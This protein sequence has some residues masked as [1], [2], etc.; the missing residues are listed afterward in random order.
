MLKLLARTSFT[1]VALLLLLATP[2]AFGAH[3][4][5]PATTRAAHHASHKPRAPRRARRKSRAVV[6]RAKSHRTDLASVT[7][8]LLGESS[9]ESQYDSLIAGQAEAFRLRAGASGFAHVAHVYIPLPN[10]ARTVIVGLYTNANNHPGSLLR[11]GS[12]SISRAGSWTA[13]S[14][15]QLELVAGKSYWL[16]ILG[17]GGILR[18]RDRAHG[19]CPSETSAR[20]TLGVLPT[21]WKTGTIYSDCPVS[22]YVTA[23]RPMPPSERTAPVEP[24]SPLEPTLPVEPIPPV[25]PPPPPTSPVNAMLPMI[26]GSTVEGQV[27]SASSGTWSGSPTSYVYQ[28]Q[29]CGSSGSGCVNVG[30]ATATSYTLA[31]S[32]VGHTMRVVV[33]AS[34]A[35]GSSSATAAATATVASDTPPPPV[36][37]TNTVLPSVSGSAVEG[38][39]LSASDGTWTGNPMSYA[40]QWEDC[41]T[42][43]ESCSN[44]SGATASSY[45]LAA[46]DVGG[47]MRVA[48]SASNAGGSASATSAPTAAVTVAPGEQTTWTAVGTPPR[49]DAQAAAL[50][51]NKAEQRPGNIAANDY[52][53][54]SA[55]L[56]SFHSAVNPY[57]QT[58]VQENPLNSYVDGLDGMTS[59]STDDLI[60]WGA[61]KWGIPADWLR[62]E[63][64]RESDWDQSNLGD[65]ASVSSSWYVLYPPLAEIAG[66]SEVFETMGIAGVKWR[67]DNSVGGGT[68]PLRWK[69]TAFNIDYQAAEVRYFYDGYCNRCTSGYGSGQQWNSIGAW[70]EPSP[71]ANAGARWYI[72][73]VQRILSEKPWLSPSF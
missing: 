9:V 41:N 64:V 26:A 28:W 32:D 35:G 16:A 63:Y 55:Q 57:G 14:I 8:V 33:I 18:Y 10:T 59:P 15:A 48:V 61:R 49:S 68:E 69:S 45:T 73:E 37:L 7:T 4:I 44:I 36:A 50:V 46:S 23:G 29:D 31:A 54:S 42:L 40:Y 3:G 6:H 43:G 51:I 13:V 38:E 39:K 56:L 20:T 52:V 53:P 11:T 58:A 17:R 12:A 60:Q 21:S 22:A 30:G 70:Y 71:W 25:E 65:R 5:H 1:A 67:P 47:T 24:S 62:A 19:P 72:A 34:N 2:P 27:L 66:T